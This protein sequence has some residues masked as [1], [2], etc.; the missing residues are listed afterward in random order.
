MGQTKIKFND[1]FKSKQYLDYVDDLFSN[2]DFFRQKKYSFLALSLLKKRFSTADLWLTHS[3]TG[4]LE[5]IAKAIRIQPG[6]EVILSS[7]TF[8]STV[9]AFVS[10]GAK[11]VFVD[12]SQ[13]DFNLNLDL[14]E[15]KITPQT[16]AI[17]ITH[18]GGHAADLNRLKSICA[19]HQLFLIEDAAMAY[20]N[21]YENQ[22]LGT[23]GDF[24]V[25]SFDVTKQISAVQGGLL[26]CNNKKYATDLDYIYHIG[27]NRTQ[28]M[29]QNKPYYEWV[30]V[31]SKYQMNELS[32][33][34][35]Y[36]NLINEEAIL[37]KRIA[38]SKHYFDALKQLPIRIISESLL[39]QNIHLFYLLLSSK[40]ERDHLQA[41]LKDRG[42]ESM[43]H[44]IP[45]H[46]SEMG[47]HFCDETLP[48]TEVV[49]DCLLRLPLHH[50]LTSEDCD[51]ICN[52]IQSYFNE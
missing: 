35:L 32:A 37:T 46:N 51:F 11:P 23:I 40:E 24:G 1:T 29:Q 31:G 27:T 34:S 41:Y 45:L 10:Q 36:D 42:I 38:L 4:G 25:I 16:K 7:F 26:L 43:F 21:D 52:T 3:A 12:V 9:N 15:S 14:I 2:Y 17:V 44:Y 28:F 5:M 49:S 13:E 50:Q 18:Y 48:V 22:P 33:I 19:A 8:V 6:D 47:R 39:N 30:S 20:G